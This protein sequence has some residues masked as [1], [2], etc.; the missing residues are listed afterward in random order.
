MLDHYRLPYDP[1]RQEWEHD[2]DKL[3]S[4]YRETSDPVDWQAVAELLRA[5]GRAVP[6]D[7]F[8]QPIR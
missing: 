6:G 3:I 4:L 5:T 8:E 7:L 1:R 2:R